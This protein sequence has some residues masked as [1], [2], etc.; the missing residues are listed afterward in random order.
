MNETDYEKIDAVRWSRLRSLRKSALQYKHDVDTEREDAA[1]F[2][3]GRAIHCFVLEPE[4]FGAHFVTYRESKSVGEGAKKNWAAFQA[5][6]ADKTI[7]NAKEYDA[8]VGAATALL[9]HPVASEYVAGGVREHTLTWTDAETGMLCKAR[10]DQ[11]DTHL[12]DIKSAREIGHRMFAATVARLGYFCQAAFY[13]DGARANGFDLDPSPILI[14]VESSAPF[15][16]A[17]YR[18]GG[19][20][21]EQGR[22]E[23]RK[24]LERLRE[25][26][27][28]DRWP[29]IAPD[30]V[31]DLVLPEWAYRDDDDPMAIIMP[32]GTAVSA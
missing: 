16:V 25:C 29:G 9:A 2:R 15:D 31:I 18:L 12:V 19:A 32:D 11:A 30:S 13:L 8:A 7:L 5:L 10:I 26:E 4:N 22:Y 20:V 6:H 14:A 28:E 1:H 3:I 24:L 23:Y 17:C 27:E 21:I